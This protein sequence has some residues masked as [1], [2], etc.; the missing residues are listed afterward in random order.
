MIPSDAGLAVFFV[1]GLFGGAHCLGMCGPLVT[2]YA[3]RF[4]DDGRGPTTSA[5]GQHVLF[6]AGRT[7][8]YATIGALLG[9][10]G[11]LVFDAGSFV[12]ATDGVRATA[13]IVA[14]FV[15]VAAGLGYVTQ[16]QPHLT[17]GAIPGLGGVFASVT[18][19]LHARIDTWAAG[20]G[21]FGLGALHGLLPCPLLYPAFLYAAASGSAVHGGLALAALGLGT[22]PTLFAYGTVLESASP[23]IRGRLHRALGVAFV[24][25]GTIPLAKGLRT[26]GY[27]VP[28]IP[29]PMP[30]IPG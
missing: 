24:V 15:I 22:F 6:N 2:M 26:L 14:G 10:A 1:V 16:G 12:T 27:D 29:L 28:Q 9:L 17:A 13:G 7:A 23:A 25:A 20:P 11:G 8:S 18:G 4:E 30:P 21:I 19:G 5:L 3:E